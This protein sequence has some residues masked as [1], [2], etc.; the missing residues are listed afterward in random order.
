M[1]VTMAATRPNVSP[2][3]RLEDPSTT[4]TLG[5]AQGF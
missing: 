1:R 5:R 2:I 3:D 4:F